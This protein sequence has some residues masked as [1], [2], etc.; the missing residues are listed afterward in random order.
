[1]NETQRE[2]DRLATI[3]FNDDDLYNRWRKYQNAHRHEIP[4]YPGSAIERAA[5]KQMKDF[6][7]K[8]GVDF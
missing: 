6:L 8:A 7:L 1:M 2:Y 5:V 4:L 3:L